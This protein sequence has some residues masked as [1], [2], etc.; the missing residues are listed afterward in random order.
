VRLKAL[1][2][3]VDDTLADTEDAHRNAF[4]D[5]FAAASGSR[6]SST[7]CHSRSRRRRDIARA[8]EMEV[9]T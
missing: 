2:F 7:R 3:D 1:I 4:N 9:L 8:D 6:I 5:A